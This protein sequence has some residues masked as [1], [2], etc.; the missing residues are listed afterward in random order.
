M[1]TIKIDIPDDLAAALRKKAAAEGMTLEGWF[2]RR[3]DQ[4]VR[5]RKGRYALAEL[6][7][8]C[9]PQVPVSP[10]VRE[11]LDSPPFGREAFWSNRG[12]L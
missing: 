6:L 10:E 11:C 7:A 9:D 8:L 5:P 1:T 4:E 3:A 2:R 12:G